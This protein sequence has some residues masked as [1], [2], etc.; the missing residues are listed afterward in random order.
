MDQRPPGSEECRVC[1]APSRPG[2]HCCFCCAVLVRRLGLPLAPLEAVA[3]YRTG[4]DLHRRLRGYKD[5][6]VAEARAACTRRL[7]TLVQGWLDD[8]A[9][10]FRFGAWDLVATVPSTRRPGPS[11]VDALVA[12]VP[13]LAPQLIG[14]LLVRGPGRL[15]HL[16]A[17][18][19]G[20]AVEPAAGER[21]AG[22]RVLVVDDTVVTGARAQ[23]AV[24]A[25][26]DAGLR[27]AGV[28]VVGRALAPEAA[29][30]PSAPPASRGGAGPGIL[31]GRS[32]PGAP[33]ASR[34]QP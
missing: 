10:D 5:A 17:D 34:S 33:P 16:V 32:R 4:D 27:P 30:W 7:A 22:R 20:F 21:A 12:A 25:L 14:G 26:R 1:G 18:R 9:G 11:P 2:F 29:A 19:R 6:P 15:D 31:A 3:T 8:R 23:S 24:A 13:T 28:L